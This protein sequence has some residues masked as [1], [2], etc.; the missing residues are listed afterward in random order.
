MN[1]LKGEVYTMR[2]KISIIGAG[3]VGASI[4]YTLTIDGVA[5]EIVLIDINKEKAKG[6]AMDILQ[7][8]AFCPPTTIY[9][10]DYPDTSNS[11]IVIITSG[12][13]RKPGQTRLDLAQNNVNLI[14]QIGPELVKYAPNA[15]YLVVSNPVDIMTYALIKTT[16]LPEHQVFGSGT[17]LDSA[18][19]RSIISKKANINP[20]NVHAYVFGEHGDSSMIPW[21][22]TSISGINLEAYNA[23]ACEKQNEFCDIN[24]KSKIEEYVKTSGSKIISM[25]GATFYAIALSV[26]NI[27]DCILRDT[28]SVLTVSGMIHNRYGIDG[29]CLSLPFILGKD[30]IVCDIT[31]P[32][33]QEEEDL[34]RNSAHTLK[35]F[36]TSLA[37]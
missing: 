1:K 10:G 12:I 21:S 32:L 4:A 5:S 17:M 37:M 30:G 26:R 25:K 20:Q 2:K 15:V 14:K 31:P 23:I 34:L 29:I 9:A 11:D 13:P 18:R 16:G 22:L 28:N 19:L 8:T 36:V 33:A 3:N 27:C 7:G 24:F 35:D 6:E